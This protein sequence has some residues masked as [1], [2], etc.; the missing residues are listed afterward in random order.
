MP[1]FRCFSDKQNL[2][3]SRILLALVA[4][5]SLVISLGYGSPAAAQAGDRLK[6]MS[7]AKTTA[8]GDLVP[9]IKVVSSDGDR[10][11]SLQEASPLGQHLFVK[12]K[13]VTKSWARIRSVRLIIGDCYKSECYWEEEN[14]DGSTTL[15][16]EGPNLYYQDLNVGK[17]TIS[18]TIEDT[19]FPADLP[20]S[21]D[22]GIAR[23][24]VADAMIS[25]CNAVSERPDTERFLYHEIPI[26]L[27]VGSEGHELGD[28]FFVTYLGDA[29]HSTTMR[30]PV[31]IQCVEYREPIDGG[32]G[33]LRL[34]D[35][36]GALT[37]LDVSL[38]TFQ[39]ET[40]DNTTSPSHGTVCK[41]ALMT[42]SAEANLAGTYPVNFLEKIGTDYNSGSL[43]LQTDFIDGKNIATYQKW[44]SVSQTSKVEAWVNASTVADEQTP[45]T[46]D[47]AE[48]TL[49]CRGSGGTGGLQT[50]LQPFEIS[51]E[52]E[53]N[54]PQDDR[55]FP[56]CPRLLEV[57]TTVRI[58][59]PGHFVSRLVCTGG[60]DRFGAHTPT[61]V[62]SDAQGHQT[63]TTYINDTLQLTETGTITCAMTATHQN[64]E[65][66]Q[67]IAVES[68][69]GICSTVQP[70]FPAP[71]GVGDDLAGEEP[72]DRS[73]V[74]NPVAA[75]IGK[76][77]FIDNRQAADQFKCPRQAKALVWF[78]N[79]SN[80]NVHY[81][82]DCNKL[83]SH[84]GVLQV[85]EAA[86]GRYT[87]AAF[88]GLPI[89]ETVSESCTLRT[90][91]PGN[92]KDHVTLEKDFICAAS[93]G[94]GSGSG[95][96]DPSTTVPPAVPDPTGQPVPTPVTP[97]LPLPPIVCIDGV[98]SNGTCVCNS[99][100]QRKKLNARTYQCVAKALPP[101]SLPTKPKDKNLV[102][103]N[104][105][106]IGGKCKCSANAKRVQLGAGVYKCRQ[107]AKRT[108][109]KITPPTRTNPKKTTPTRTNPKKSK[110]IC[111][112]GQV[113]NGK[114]RC[115]ANAKRV[116]IGANAY[117]CRPIAK[118]ANPKNSGAKRTNPK[119]I[120]L[121]CQGGQVQGGKCRCGSKKVRRK[122]K[123]NTYKCARK[124]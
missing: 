118:R 78:T 113:K 116:K 120:K 28:G 17:K 49:H 14:E 35:D 38:R 4:V 56:E 104:G 18:R 24:L 5:L 87:G 86:D 79:A 21:G 102:C 46:I 57:N 65:P 75:V 61:V 110:L 44:I 42:I 20:V 43:E 80:D 94:H 13:V 67:L 23:F 106:I 39:N 2:Y 19:F 47:S 117:Q 22:D 10:W 119:K 69:N 115:S 45:E 3:C 27:G 71:G 33:E 121:I 100:Q 97:P 74:G 41:K 68:Y 36:N 37:N 32:A 73:D 60:L 107:Q 95:L 108:N 85:S 111:K 124:P 123:A 64:G 93:A 77:Q 58:N 52:M 92:P 16:G 72:D 59:R 76:F 62:A 29:F 114:C 81:S 88:V 84:S 30:Y 103:Q 82:L 91:S 31:R 40:P 54:D 89:S 55:A 9:L 11:D 112:S 109:P 101:K 105:S 6:E 53:I 51:A 96:A 12:F 25:A 8:S 1:Y 83:G 122:I 26:T 15:P 34:D 98:V 50:E 99:A 90:V 66:E 63:H 7:V 48:L 70:G